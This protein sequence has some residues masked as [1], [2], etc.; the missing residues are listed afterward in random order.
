MRILG[1]ARG[2]RCSLQVALREDDS[3]HSRAPASLLPQLQPGSASSPPLVSADILA[4]LIA[5]FAGRVGIQV[6]PRKQ[7]VLHVECY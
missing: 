1:A 7:M 2:R 5:A 3:R 6:G 4:P